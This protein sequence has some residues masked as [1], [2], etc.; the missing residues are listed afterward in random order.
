MGHKEVLCKVPYFAAL[1]DGEWEDCKSPQ[2]SLPCS[3]EEFGLL[4]QRLYT[5]DALGTRALPV[6]DCA[7]AVRLAAAAGMLLIDENVPE[8]S[9]LLA[10][11]VKDPQDVELVDVAMPSL[12]NTFQL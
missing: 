4:V 3:V 7:S 6:K 2:V 5:G 11:H 12:P 9:D 1:L 10:E 8:L